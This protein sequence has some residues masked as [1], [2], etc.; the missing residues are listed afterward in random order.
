M[1]ADDVKVTGNLKFDLSATND[2]ARLA[3]DLKKRFQFDGSRPLIVAASTHEPEE[4]W[5]IESLRESLSHDAR[6]LIAPRHPERFDAIAKLLFDLNLRSVRRSDPAS[7]A[8]RSADVVLLDSVGE[9]RAVLR[10]ADIVFVGG[11]L[12]PHGGQSVLEPALFGKAIVTGPYTHN[13]NDVVEA[14]L[15]N[16]ALMQLPETTD[17][18]IVSVLT[19]QI[20]ELL[21]DTAKRAEFGDNARSVIEAN[22]GATAKTISELTTIFD[23]E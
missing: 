17:G 5:I 2:E 8:D 22:R 23:G 18:E 14:F 21:H 12:I 4:K 10:L 3:E 1:N 6:L 20:N 16:R 15:E 13:F 7:D 19:G 11:S 9:L